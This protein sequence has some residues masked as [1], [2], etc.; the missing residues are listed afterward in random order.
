LENHL[1]Q[2]WAASFGYGTPG[3]INDV[4]VSVDEK[5]NIQPSAYSLMQ[6]YPNPFNPSTIIR[7]SLPQNSFVTLRIFDIIGKEVATLVNEEKLSGVYEVEFKSLIGSYQLASGL[8]FYQLSAKGGTDSFLE[9]KK[10]III[11]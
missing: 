2:N 11:K 9:T 5:K 3:K 4:F 6:N 8:Y 7:F 1:P 10:M